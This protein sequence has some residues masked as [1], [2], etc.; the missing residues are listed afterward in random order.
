MKYI[1]SKKVSLYINDVC[2]SM[3]DV[4]EHERTC[5]KCK[6]KTNRRSI[7]GGMTSIFHGECGHTWEVSPFGKKLR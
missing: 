1:I 4:E 5:P 2:I 6:K 7:D 3:H